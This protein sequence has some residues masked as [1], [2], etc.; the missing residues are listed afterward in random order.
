MRY[1]IQFGKVWLADEL[2]ATAAIADKLVDVGSDIGNGAD[3]GR[4]KLMYSRRLSQEFVSAAAIRSFPP[5]Q[6]E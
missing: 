4:L 3:C 6:I 1:L 5:A 2:G